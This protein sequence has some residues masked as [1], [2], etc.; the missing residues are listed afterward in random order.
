MNV[1]Y[2][3]GTSIVLADTLSRSP[4]PQMTDSKQ[5]SFEIFRVDVEESVKVNN[6]NLTTRITEELQMATR[7]DPT[8]SMLAQTIQQG[9]PVNKA[10][11]NGTLTPYWPF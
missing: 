7:H 4:L 1:I 8:I 6:P 3:K 9:W 2:K 10:E 5:T 11:L